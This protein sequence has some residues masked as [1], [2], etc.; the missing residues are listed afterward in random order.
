M[1]RIS[2]KHICNYECTHNAPGA[3]R[4]IN[5]A[6]GLQCATHLL[7]ERGACRSKN[8]YSDALQERRRAI[9]RC[10]EAAV[11]LRGLHMIRRKANYCDGPVHS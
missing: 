2:I 5:I 11:L 9:E 1:A 10:G 6:N 4:E 3:F 7:G 8:I